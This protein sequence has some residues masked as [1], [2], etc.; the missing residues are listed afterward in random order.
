MRPI[1]A[2]I[3]RLLQAGTRRQHAQTRH[4][5]AKIL[6]M[7]AAPWTFVTGEGVTPTNNGAERALRRAVLCRR[8]SFGT[9]SAEGSV[10]VARLLTVVTTVRRQERDVLDDLTDACAAR[11]ADAPPPSL[12]PQAQQPMFTLPLLAAA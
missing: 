1:Q 3:G 9:Q 6:K 12:L 11:L 5:Y 7:E 4:T 2:R 10:C 8:R